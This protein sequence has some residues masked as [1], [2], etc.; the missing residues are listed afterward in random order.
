LGTRG[1]EKWGG[2]ENKWNQRGAGCKGRGTGQKSPVGGT[3]WARVKKFKPKSRLGQYKKRE[4]NCYDQRSQPARK[5]EEGWGKGHPKGKSSGR[6]RLLRCQ[7][8]NAKRGGR[9]HKDTQ[10][11]PGARLGSKDTLTHTIDG[12]CSPK[13]ANPKRVPRRAAIV[14]SGGGEGWREIHGTPAI[15]EAGIQKKKNDL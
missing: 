3:L 13:P 9:T 12:A 1:V 11:I 14:P 5:L 8:V 10:V 6:Q 7:N 2:P 4:K 15:K